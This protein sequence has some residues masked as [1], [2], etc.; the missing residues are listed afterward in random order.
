MSGG[1]YFQPGER[2][3]NPT[4]VWRGYIGKRL[5]EVSTK[6]LDQTQAELFVA[7]LTVE[8][9]QNAGDQ[10]PSPKED[11]TFK[12]GAELY[13]A[14]A[15]PSADQRRYLEKLKAN[16]LGRK[17]VR[18]IEHADL[19]KAA[20]EL[21][22]E[23]SSE[24]KNRQAMGPAA[25]VLH[26]CADNKYCA[27]LRV[28]LFKRQRA[29]TRAVSYDVARALVSNV[30][31]LTVGE[32]QHRRSLMAPPAMIGNRPTSAKDL[33]R[34]QKKQAKRRLL[35]MWLFR[36]GMRITN[37][38]SIKLEQIDMVARTVTYRAAKNGIDVTK[39]IAA[40]VFELLA[41]DPDV[42][43]GGRGFLFPWRTRRSVYNWLQPYVREALN[44]KFTPHMARHTLGKELNE[45]GASLRTIMDTLDHLD[46]ASSVRYQSTD[47]EVVRARTERLKPLSKG[48]A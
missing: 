26:Y 40:E 24:T 25:A 29:A 44:V 18:Q 19:V 45:D 1:R 10:T 5:V 22:P 6:T 38:L 48:A 43:A 39:P 8:L 41:E 35:M 28:K 11:L 47:V 20:N 17:F 42:K 14:F 34:F 37:S 13:E 7:N 4:I 9:L 12:R 16:A 32:G 36:Q 31:L 15:N 46:K 30:P 23:G 21:Y 3:N 2:K 33:A 27:W